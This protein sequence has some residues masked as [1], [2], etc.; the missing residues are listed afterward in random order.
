MG[1]KLKEMR[2]FI[3]Q[4]IFLFY[5]YYDKGSTKDIAYESAVLAFVG[6]TTLNI[7]AILNFFDLNLFF[8]VNSDFPR[9]LKYLIGLGIYL[10]PFFFLVKIYFPKK[11]ITNYEMNKS[12]MRQ[13]Y[14]LI[15]FHIVISIILLI[16]ST[17]LT[18]F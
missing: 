4:F 7:A 10:L 9:A 6:L 17:E 2:T 18:P 8:I 11:V 13:G 16:L 1:R 5:K 12:A 14:F 15:V 3:K